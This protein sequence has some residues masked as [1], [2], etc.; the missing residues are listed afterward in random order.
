M[1][2]DDATLMNQLRFI[3]ESAA[4]F[5]LAAQIFSLISLRYFLLL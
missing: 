4:P 1:F 3:L 2:N 5:S